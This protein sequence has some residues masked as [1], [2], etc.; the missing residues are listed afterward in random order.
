MRL[1]REAQAQRYLSNHP[2]PEF[3]QA[4]ADRERSVSFAGGTEGDAP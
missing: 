1:V 3:R 2:L 4:Y